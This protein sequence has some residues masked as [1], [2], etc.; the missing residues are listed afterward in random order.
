MNEV[1]FLARR[2]STATDAR[3]SER[4]SVSRSTEFGL[5][6]VHWRGPSLLAD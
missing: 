5:F 1:H 6:H 4:D 3:V 2:N